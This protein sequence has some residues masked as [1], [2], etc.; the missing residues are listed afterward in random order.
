L[1]TIG[2]KLADITGVMNPTGFLYTVDGGT[3]DWMYGKL[4]VPAY[5]FEIG[6]TSGSCGDFFPAYGCQDGIDGMPRNFWAEMGPSF[7]YANKIAGSPYKT[8]YG[9]DTVALLVDPSVVP[10][11]LPVNLSGTVIDQRY[12]SDPLVPITAAEYFIDA[13]GIDGSGQAMSPADGAWGGTNEG[14]IAVVDTSGLT[15]GQHYILVHGMN[16]NGFWGPF[17]AIFLDVTTPTYGVML[18]PETDSGQADPGT[19][20]TYT[21]QVLNVGQNEDTYDINVDSQWVFS[22][23]PTIGPIPVGGNASFDL[24]VTIPADANNGEADVATVTVESQASPGVLDS[25]QLTTTAN[26]YALTLLPLAKEGSGNPGDQVYYVLHLTN[27]GNT[28]DTFDLESSSIW[29]VTLQG[30]VGP[31]APGVTEDINVT[32]D[33]PAGA[34]PGESDVAT[35]TATSQGDNSK[36]TSSSL[37]TS[38]T[39]VYSFQVVPLED[40]LIGH[41][42]GTTVEYSVQVTNTGNITDTYN[43]HI[44]PGGWPVDA[45]LEVGP[46]ARNGSTTVTITVH[47]PFNIAMGDSNDTTLIIISQGS[48]IGHQVFLHTNT[49]WHSSFLPLSQKH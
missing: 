12:L 27:T 31:M 33:V 21:L 4:G 2:R 43:I 44:S 26:Y 9:P 8:A 38:V 35:I 1:R 47:I 22:V 39:T 37:T 7:L 6:P 23:P 25:S 10:A 30:S 29:A 41:G 19:N 11:G 36:A 20:V 14:V 24:E 15:E 42:R 46:I 3:I 17:T 13:P 16:S 48:S 40:T 45:P 32:V 5:T 49:F 34:S 18:T 28:T